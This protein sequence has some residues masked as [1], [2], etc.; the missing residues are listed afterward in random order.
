MRAVLCTWI[1]VNIFSRGI[2]ISHQIHVAWQAAEIGSDRRALINYLITTSCLINCKKL[3]ELREETR[4]YV[5]G[6]IYMIFMG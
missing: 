4:F 2:P 6:I 5:G 3:N 1:Q